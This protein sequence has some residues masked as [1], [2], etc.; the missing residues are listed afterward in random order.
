MKLNAQGEVFGRIAI[1]SLTLPLISLGIEHEEPMLLVLVFW[2]GYLFAK[3]PDIGAWIE[4]D[5]EGRDEL[6]D[7]HGD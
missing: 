5:N 6:P 2:V 7:R 3:A 1:A 4:G